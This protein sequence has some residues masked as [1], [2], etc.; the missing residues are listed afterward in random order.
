ML[1]QLLTL[2]RFRF[3]MARRAWLRVEIGRFAGALLL[4]GILLMALIGTAVGVGLFFL[5]WRVMADGGPM[6]VLIVGDMLAFLV[7]LAWGVGL[8]SE[9]QRSDTIDFRKMLYLPVSLRMVFVL[10]FVAS[11]ASPLLIVFVLGTAGLTFGLVAGAGGRMWLAV[12]LAAAFY[13]ML[14]TWSYH[15]RGWLGVLME[16]KRRRRLI[17]TLIPLV[18]VLISQL[19][20][21]LFGYAG[22][23]ARETVGR[24][25]PSAKELEGMTQEQRQAWWQEREA[26]LLDRV[27]LYHIPLPPAWLPLALT[28]VDR[29]RYGAAALCFAGMTGLAG[30]GLAAGYRSTLRHYTAA[31]PRRARP[32]PKPR[33]TGVGTP[34]T[35]RP[36]AGLA[37]DTAAYAL[38]SWL[39]AL[40]HPTVRMQLIMPFVFGVI[41][42][43]PVILN[44]ASPGPFGGSSAFG[45]IAFMVLASFSMFL[46][47]AFGTDPEGFQALVLLPTPRHRYLI[48][49]NLA[50]FP[51]VGLLYAVF[52]GISLVLFAAK[53]MLIAIGTIHF[54][55][56]YLS[57]CLL[58]NF[59]SIY[60][61]Y[62][63]RK[64]SMN[65][66]GRK[67]AAFLTGLISLFAI[68][69]LMIPSGITVLVHTMLGAVPGFTRIP[70]GLL[71]A[72]AFFVLTA[73]AYG[74][75]LRPA[76]RLLQAREQ[77]ILA[78]LQK[79]RD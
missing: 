40:R 45:L 36:L 63:M 6:V 34:L 58:G 60:F 29:G 61:P 48:G 33:R 2:V 65:A 77:Q 22:H 10:N 74:L 14:A 11:L 27:S 78:T 69:A 47:N 20:N 30:L 5:G 75:T 64:D 56:I 8:L 43:L 39:T 66:A 13:L 31:A 18:F 70:V 41:F 71:M 46:F 53:P 42:M 23:R 21:L 55:Q 57:L 59:L 37:D 35:G 38:A 49:K 15:F 1:V 24:A 17:L 79:D 62:R 51:I 16:N 28:A 3:L 9:V 32:A 72:M 54:L 67:P 4:A 7:L 44:P 25:F 12:P 73:T 19:P 68:P 26:L 50:Y 52:A 76:G